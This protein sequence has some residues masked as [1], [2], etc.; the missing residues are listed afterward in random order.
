MSFQPAV[1]TALK[2]RVALTGPT[3]AGKTWT[4]LEWAERFAQGGTVAVIDTERDSA[5]RYAHRF[6][7]SVWAWNA[8]YRPDALAR[9]LVDHA[10]A[11]DVMVVD[12]LSHFWEGEGGTLD[13]VDAAAARSRSGNSYTAW[14]DVTPVQRALIDTLVGLPCHLI[15]TMRA[16][17]EYAAETDDRGKIVPKRIGLAP[18]QRHGVEYEFDVVGELDL[19]HT[20]TFSKARCDTLDGRTFA[21]GRTAEAADELRDWLGDGAQLAS[22]ADKRRIKAA[23]D[24]SASVTAS[25]VTAQFGPANALRASQVDEVVTWIESHSPA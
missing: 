3:G 1:K 5:R 19:L 17:M 20:L 7:F 14:R 15:V 21:R 16:R 8:P 24:A 12:S 13:M 2:A 23:L 10:A 6:A 11:Y 25:D 4:A 9:V 22:S 18:V